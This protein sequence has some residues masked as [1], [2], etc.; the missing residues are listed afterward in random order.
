[1]TR[2]FICA[3]AV[4]IAI[5][6]SEHATSTHGVTSEPRFVLDLTLRLTVDEV[7]REG[8]WFFQQLD[9]GRR[10]AMSPGG[11]TVDQVLPESQILNGV[12]ILRIRVQHNCHLDFPHVVSVVWGADWTPGRNISQ[13]FGTPD[14]CHASLRLLPAHVD[15]TG[16]RTAVAASPQTRPPAAS[17]LSSITPPAFVRGRDRVPGRRGSAIE[18]RASP[19]PQ[20][21]GRRRTNVTLKSP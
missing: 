19:C 2:R 15:T 16:G 10:L 17:R 5:D 7:E 21:A 6:V 14:Q 3:T 9:R 18:R 4:F 8:W 20:S 12:G 11:G 13:R 1:M